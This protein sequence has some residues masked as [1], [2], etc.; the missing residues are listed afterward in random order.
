[1]EGLN[2]LI[3]L[4]LPILAAGLIQVF[5][6][7]GLDNVRDGVHTLI[8]VI[9]FTFVCQ[10]IPDV[11]D[12]KTPEFVLSEIFPGLQIG[13]KVEPLGLLFALGF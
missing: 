8:A 2:I 3:P 4:L 10:L 13:W 9:T 1:M 11:M 6:R 5:G 12:G 7:L